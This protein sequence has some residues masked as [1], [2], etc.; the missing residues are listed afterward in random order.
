MISAGGVEVD[1]TEFVF[2]A[3]HEIT[4]HRGALSVGDAT[5]T[6][7]TLPSWFRLCR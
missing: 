6:H 7:M 2:E 1:T 4:E 3:E 5:V